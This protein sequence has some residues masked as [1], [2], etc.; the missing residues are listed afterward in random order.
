[1][2]L[3]SNLDHCYCKGVDNILRK[4]TIKIDRRSSEQII[5]FM[6]SGTLDKLEYGLIVNKNVL[7]L[8][9]YQTNIPISFDSSN[10]NIITF[11]IGNYGRGM[12]ISYLPFEV[13]VL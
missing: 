3:F 1:M 11:S 5:F 8:N 13:E 6:L 2:M 7:I 9:K 4:K 12:F 10:S